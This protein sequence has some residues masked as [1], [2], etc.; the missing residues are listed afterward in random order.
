MGKL[1]CAILSLICMVCIFILNVNYVYADTIKNKKIEVLFISSFNS[2]FITFNDQVEGIRSGFN[3]NCN[4]NIEYMDFKIFDSYE[5]E[6]NFFN[7]LKYKLETY[8]NID[9][10]IAG[11]DEATEFC[12]KYRND[13]FENIPISFLGVQDYVRRQR[14]LQYDLV[15]GVTEVESI[16]ENIEL[17]KKFHPNVDTI[18]FIDCYRI[19]L[20]EEIISKYDDLIFGFVR[21]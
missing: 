8:E 15:S 14:A 5:A 4:I 2:D 13:L 21:L 20:Y 10:I 19:N 11:D 7:L 16:K 1:R 6:E 3:N 9:V 17:I 12:I 18:T